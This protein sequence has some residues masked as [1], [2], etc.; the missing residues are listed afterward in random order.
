MIC[1]DIEEEEDAE[2]EEP[3]GGAA[4]EEDTSATSVVLSATDRQS[5]AERRGALC[6]DSEEEEDAEEEEPCGGAE[7]E[8][9]TS[10]TSV[11]LS[12]SR[13][14]VTGS[15]MVLAGAG[16]DPGARSAGE[17]LAAEATAAVSVGGGGTASG[18]CTPHAVVEAMSSELVSRAGS[19]AAGGRGG[20][21]GY[22][23]AAWLRLGVAKG[24][25]P[26]GA[27]R[28]ES[29][30]GCD[31]CL[32]PATSV[33]PGHSDVSVS[34]VSMVLVEKPGDCVAAW[35]ASGRSELTTEP[36][37]GE[38]AAGSEGSGCRIAL[39][40]LLARQ[41]QRGGARVLGCEYV[42]TTG[43]T[44]RAATAVE[45]GASMSEMKAPDTLGEPTAREPA[46]AGEARESIPSWAPMIEEAAERV[47]AADSLS[48]GSLP[49]LRWQQWGGVGG[50]VSGMQ[51][52]VTVSLAG[53]GGRGVTVGPQSAS[54]DFSDD[55]AAPD[56]KEEGVAKHTKCG[57][58]EN[59][60]GA[61][62]RAAATKVTTWSVRGTQHGHELL[63]TSCAGC[64]S[65]ETARLSMGRG[66]LVSKA[67]AAGAEG[68]NGS[69]AV[70]TVQLSVLERRRG[71]SGFSDNEEAPWIQ[72][73]AERAA[74]DGGSN[75]LVPPLLQ[76]QR[77]DGVTDARG[78]VPL[79]AVVTSTAGDDRGGAERL[80]SVIG[81]RLQVAGGWRRERCWCMVPW[82]KLGLRS[83]GR[84][85]WC[86]CW[87]QC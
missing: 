1:G 33:G 11:V 65:W 72:A 42:S 79:T 84:C 28:G 55:G 20:A 56:G 87:W 14:T 48:A 2:E 27:G 21:S 58:V 29:T 34:S 76:R 64:A 54:D 53:N 17:S 30:R 77:D 6:E 83:S 19:T 67:T 47:A 5:P 18:K 23:R 69:E 71:L 44:A 81:E 15:A 36:V 51:V 73:A 63:R 10:A 35:N 66:M 78:S 37:R 39:A 16:V 45:V 59:R 50:T 74:A 38:T 49:P 43:L 86:Y 60:D 62:D 7:G 85:C 22:D 32:V 25:K 61:S 57:E 31:S 70:A 68:G 82:R 26:R 12:A 4:K 13:V 3:C 80:Q 40:L 75:M 24:H 52:L 41:E 46:A 8:E 9:D